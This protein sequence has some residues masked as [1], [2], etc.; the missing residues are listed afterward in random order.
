MNE[1]E[2]SLGSIGYITGSLGYL[3]G[4]MER[5]EEPT[6]HFPH[7]PLWK[8]PGNYFPRGEAP[9]PYEEAVAA[10]RAEALAVAMASGNLHS[11]HP[12]YRF[13]ALY[14]FVTFIFT[15]VCNMTSL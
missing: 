13:V 3:P 11:A 14:K 12:N 10:T 6:A 7:Y 4:A 9:P 1:D 2:R 8:P 15:I 5:Y